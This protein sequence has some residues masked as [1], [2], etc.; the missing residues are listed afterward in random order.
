MAL[1]SE[2]KN[3]RGSYRS[4]FMVFGNVVGM[5]VILI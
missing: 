4:A 5:P 1:G 2:L 3:E